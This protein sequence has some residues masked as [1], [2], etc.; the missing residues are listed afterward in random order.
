MFSIGFFLKLVVGVFGALIFFEGLRRSRSDQ[1]YTDTPLLLPLGIFVWGDAL[2]LGPFWL[3]SSVIWQ[4]LDFDTI[5]K[6]YLAFLA[7]RS[8]YETIYWIQHQFA[9]KDYQPPLVRRISWLGAEEA[10]I[11]YQLLN[12]CVVVISVVMLGFVL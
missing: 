7:V 12:M 11:V 6:Y 9:K 3:I 5:L 10:G 1:F 8:A 2:V 4:F